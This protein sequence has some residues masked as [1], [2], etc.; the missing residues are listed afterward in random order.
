MILVDSRA[1]SCDLVKPLKDMGLPV[2]ETTLEYGDLCFMGRG[3]QGAHVYV[4]IEH[5][6]LPDLVQSLATGRLQD[7][8]L[9]GMLATYDRMW[10]VIEGDWNHD[11]NGRVAMFKGRGERRPLKGAPPA[12][13]LE[14]RILCL[15]TRG[16]FRVRHC[17]TRRDTVRFLCALYRF[18]NDKDLDQHT[19]HLAIHAPDLDRGLFAPISLKR[20]LASQLPGIGFQRSRAVDAHFETIVEMANA[21]A[22]EWVKIEGIGK[23]I[24]ANIV[25]TLRERD[26]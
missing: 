2:E 23:T 18:W 7:T 14:K 16:G 11:A 21:P 17:P 19:S 26:S 24:A 8:Q 10:L 3:E 22:E 13:E 6:K 20:R 5:K 25:A 9:R 4:G 1:G 15:E 12:I